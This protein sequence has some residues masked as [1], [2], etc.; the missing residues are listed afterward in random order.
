MNALGLVHQLS[1]PVKVRAR[2]N[3]VGEADSVRA[4]QP[5]HAY[6]TA[7]P[8]PPKLHRYMTPESA[9]VVLPP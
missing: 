5:L 4:T 8:A 7:Q 6:L 2:H 9:F 3:I 1:R